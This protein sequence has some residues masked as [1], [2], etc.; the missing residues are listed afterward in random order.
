MAAIAGFNGSVSQGTNT[1]ANVQS[2]ELPLAAGMYDVSVMGT[3]WQQYIPGLN[4]A[5]GKISG[6]FDT[7]DTNGQVA[8]LNAELNGTL[9]T[10]KLYVSAT[11]YFSGSAYISDVDVK[12][13]VNAPVTADFSAQF[14]GAISYT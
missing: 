9:M 12:T 14:T 13:P 2:W 11:H 4:G 7:T 8:L 5:K 6:F 3:S 10:L 1:V